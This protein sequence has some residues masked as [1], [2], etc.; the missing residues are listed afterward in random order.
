MPF[1]SN[2]P[3]ITCHFYCA[4]YTALHK[5]KIDYNNT[6]YRLDIKGLIAPAYKLNADFSKS[7]FKS[8]NILYHK[9]ESVVLGQ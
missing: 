4:K 7:H 6:G 1:T 8:I 2:I 3:D 5:I 9:I